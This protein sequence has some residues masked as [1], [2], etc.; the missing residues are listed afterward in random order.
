M[1]AEGPSVSWLCVHVRACGRETL[2]FILLACLLLF[3]VMHVSLQGDVTV[4]NAPSAEAEQGAASQLPQQRRSQEENL[5]ARATTKSGPQCGLK[6]TQIVTS[7]CTGMSAEYISPPTSEKTWV[8][9]AMPD[10]ISWSW[11]LRSH[12]ATLALKAEIP[13][14]ATSHLTKITPTS[15]Q[16]TLEKYGPERFSTSFFA[17]C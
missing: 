2:M 1:V 11:F 10:T 5:R 8:G 7:C 15:G 13:L 16:E 9:G 12:S 4:L 17:F 14:R 6:S 3:G